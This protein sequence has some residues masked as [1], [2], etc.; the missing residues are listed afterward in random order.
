MTLGSNAM[1]KNWMNS[2]KPQRVM[3]VAILSQACQ[4]W[5]EGA[6]TRWC[7]AISPCNTPVASSTPAGNAVGDDIV[8]VRGKS[9]VARI[10][11]S[12]VQIAEGPPFSHLVLT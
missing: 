7:G 1:W 4:A 8:Q 9:L 11:R 6:E 12:G 5:Q 10:G 2:G 3:P